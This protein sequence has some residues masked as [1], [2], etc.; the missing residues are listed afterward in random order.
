MKEIAERRVSTW[1]PGQ[2]LRLR[3][4]MEAISFASIMSV[5][6]GSEDDSTHEALGELI[7]EMMDRCD[8]PFAL[9]PW[10]HREVG[11]LSPGPGCCGC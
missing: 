8:S 3:D 5:V 2:K 6:F 10:F 1:E 4:E 11:G 7:L 9:I